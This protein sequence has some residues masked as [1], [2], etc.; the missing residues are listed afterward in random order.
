MQPTR[1]NDAT[2]MRHAI[3]LARRAVG[4]T[5]PNPAVGCVIA[6]DGAVLA[7]GF[8]PR[9]GAPHAEA[10]ALANCTVDPRGATMYV[11]LE[12]CN[13]TGR[14]PPCSEAII[15]AGIARVVIGT[16]DPNPTAG[17]G[18]ERLRAAGIEVTAGVLAHECR[19]IDPAFHL[20]HRLGRPMVTLKWAMTA[21]GCTSSASGDSKWI[22]GEASRQYVHQLRAE[23]D[24]ILVGV[25]TA[26][27]DDARLTVRGVPGADL[28]APRRRM[29][30]DSGLSL[31]ANHVLLSEQQGIATIVCTHAASNEAEDRLRCAGADVWRVDADAEG[32][33][34][35]NALME[36]LKQERVQSLLVEGGRRVAGAFLAAGLVDRVVAFV[37]PT[38]LGGG[39]N[40]LGALLQSSPPLAMTQAVALKH[41]EW[42]FFDNDAL[43]VGWCTEI[44]ED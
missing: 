36:R 12:P 16:C 18:I 26:L 1:T 10:M 27:K 40:H 42:R 11:T 25:S 21:D 29:V 5:R 32:R 24:A 17:G 30:L 37:A 33:V 20:F 9:A 35:L 13:H 34:D 23:C 22:S 38:L 4:C 7:E 14:T 28:G 2:W 15:R 43:L 44:A 41:A 6:R 31:P 19:L 39:E 3:T 8:H